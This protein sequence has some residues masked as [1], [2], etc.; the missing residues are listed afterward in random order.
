MATTIDIPTRAL[1]KTAEVCSIAQVQPYVLRSWETEF[2]GLGR[3]TGGG[4]RVYR[5]ADVELVL[6]IKRLVY[7]EGL[8]LGAAQ[9]QL[10]GDQHDGPV[11]DEGSIAEL[12]G[13]DARERIAG[14]KEGLRAVLALL[15][16]NGDAERGLFDEAPPPTPEVAP[17]PQRAVKARAPR[18][19]KARAPASAKRKGRH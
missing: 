2:P 14:V 17:T 11:E 15:S 3:V 5:R 10:G 13:Q 6:E 16:T 1:Y 19:V 12:L 8:T 18:K 9:R 4:A 7:Q